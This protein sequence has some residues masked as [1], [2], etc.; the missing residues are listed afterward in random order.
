[1]NLDRETARRMLAS[2]LRRFLIAVAGALLC[3]S[4]IVEA[5]RTGPAAEGLPEGD[6]IC[7]GC[8]GAGGLSKRLPSGDDWSL[9]VDGATFARSVHGPIGCV[10]CHAEVKPPAHPVNATAF[11]S[12]REHA[13]ARNDSCRACHA[14][15]FKVYEGSSHATRLRA[16]SLAAPVC[17]DCHRPHQV[18][19]ASVQ[20]GPTNAC[21]GCHGDTTEQ[22]EQWLPNP[23]SH[24]RSV[25]CSAC[26]APDALRRV[27]LRI[28]VGANPLQDRDG[29]LQFERRARAADVN[30]DG[31]DA[32][33]LRGLLADLEGGGEA[34]SLRGRIELRSGI[35]AHEL[36]GKARALREC[37]G[38]HD[39][40]ALPFQ[41]VTVSIL[42]AD[43]RPL[44][45]DA[46]RG[47]LSSAIT[48]EAL[49]G[50]YAI[51]GT[52]LG[53]LDVL[54]A[55]GLAGG[56]AVPALHLAARRW[57]GRRRHHQPD[58]ADT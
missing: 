5:A 34:L 2:T 39:Q 46:H 40:S 22:H 16:G 33:E 6:G 38:C 26:H 14:R 28:L 13:L 17:G 54:L 20:D 56:I 55:L 24:L 30:H 15:V 10:G 42:D 4:A 29:T 18:T 32:N 44:R 9:T 21:T 27:D 51:G 49:R 53:Q 47:V 12:E 25:A 7:L 41:H 57:F 37:T 35:E 48:W 23:A 1:M 43:G 3:A 8:H 31:L 19:P 45:Y 50:F 52:R 11:A 58:G 36:P